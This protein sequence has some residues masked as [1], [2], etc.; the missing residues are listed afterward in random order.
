MYNY[1]DYKTILSAAGGMNVYRGCTHG[2]IYC[3]TR[4][5]CYQLKNDLED[6]EVKRNAA[7][8]LDD[9]L[10]R[11]RK[12][13]MIST[14]SMC[15]PYIP[16]EA[17]LK[18][19]RSCLEVIAAHRF[20]VAVLTK[21]DL[22]LRDIDVLTQINEQT[23][24]VVQTTLTTYDEDLCATLEPGVATTARRVE[25]LRAMR[26]A[27][28][29]TV[30]W[31][32][33]ILPYINDSE[34]NLRGLLDYCVDAGVAGILCFGFGVTLRSGS[35]EHYYQQLDQ[36][37]P[38]MKERYMREFGDSYYCMS[39]HNA[40]LMRI[41]TDTCRGAG[42]MYETDQIWQYLREFPEDKSQLSL[43]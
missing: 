14:G 12:P 17:K 7:A 28:I 19:T 22:V 20:G 38:G 32:G 39:P 37:A 18:V 36:L 30:V 6:V 15:D 27:D 41:F 43:F 24:S 40:R 8:I 2:C 11:K 33:P 21:S 16:L 9:Q 42:I 26:D 34:E 23:K 5:E 3:D 25:V 10:R 29:P 31:L 4:S 1:G 13:Q 35:R